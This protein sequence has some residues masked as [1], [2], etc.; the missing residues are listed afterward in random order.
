MA[1]VT[2]S[3]LGQINGA[4][5]LDALF[6]KQFS[7]EV[8]TAYEAKCVYKDKHRT[9]TIQNGK[10]AQFPAMGVSSAA[11]HTPGTSLDGAAFGLN[12][13]VITIDDMLIAHD[14]VSDIEEMKNHYDV[15]G[16]ISQKL[17]YALALEFDKHVAQVGVLASRAA[18]TITGQPGGTAIAGGAAVRTTGTLISTA[19]FASAQKMDENNVPEMNRNAFMKPVSFY[20]AAKETSLINKDWGGAGSLAQGKIET[21]AGI[22]I[23]KTNQLP[24]TNITTGPTAYRG[25]FTNTA[26]SVLNEE[27]VGTVQLMGLSMQAEYMT[28]FQATLMAARLAVGHGILR[29]ECAIEI[30][31]T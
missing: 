28:W 2:L 23:V 29:P 14:W 19:L 25:D 4:G 18:A 30:T 16:P 24:S 20:A 5:A 10:S 3:P 13:R 8:L 31:A 27:A 11:Y 15:R 12:E 17:G 22:S 1:T 6:L 26:I 21:L 7:G 9:R